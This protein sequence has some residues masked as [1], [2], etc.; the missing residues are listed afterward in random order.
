MQQ[1]IIRMMQGGALLEEWPH[2]SSSCKKVT[3]SKYSN[4]KTCQVAK[5]ECYS[6]SERKAMQLQALKDAARIQHMIQ[7]C[8]HHEGSS[9]IRYL[10]EKKF[11]RPED[12]LGIEHL[13]ADA[14]KVVRE[15]RKHVAVVLNKQ[16]EVKESNQLK[17]LPCHKKAH[18]K[19]GMELARISKARSDKSIQKA[20]LRAILAKK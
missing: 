10:L 13:I 20:Q 2:V 8:P 3:F 19:F 18:D 15:R 14:N 5:V 4:M 11:L 9:A 16:Q 6:S 7:L 12:L 1:P 17:E